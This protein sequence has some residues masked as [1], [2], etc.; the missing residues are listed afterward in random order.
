[1]DSKKVRKPTGRTVFP[2]TM[3]STVVLFSL[4]V[5]TTFPILSTMNA[6]VSNKMFVVATTKVI[7]KIKKKLVNDLPTE[8]DSFSQT[9]ITSKILHRQI[10]T[11]KQISAQRFAENLKKELVQVHADNPHQGFLHE[12]DELVRVETPINFDSRQRGSNV[13]SSSGKRS[14][15]RSN[16]RSSKN[17]KGSNIKGISLREKTRRTK[18]LYVKSNAN[19][20]SIERSNFITETKTDELI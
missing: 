7:V 12:D 19:E 4:L 8:S 17:N 2:M 15:K 3:F 20:S 1:M 5:A 6:V 10:S 13:T 11:K 9:K 18:L 16:K 14:N